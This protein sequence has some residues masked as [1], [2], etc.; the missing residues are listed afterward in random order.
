MFREN[1][2]RKER[3]ST[4]WLLVFYDCLIFLIAAF[5]VFIY[6]HGSNHHQAYGGLPLCA[7]ALVLLLAFRFLFHVYRQVWRSNAIGAYARLLIADILAGVSFVLIV[8]YTRFPFFSMSNPLM[9]SLTFVMLNLVLS[10]WARF[11]YYYLFRYATGHKKYSD[12]LRK[13]L[14]PITL[15]DFDTE[16]G[17][18]GYTLTPKRPAAQPINEIMHVIAQFAIRGKVTNIKPLNKGYINRSF[19]VETVSESGTTHRYTLQRI[20]TN[21]FRD[22]E[23]LMKNFETV[24]K[25]LSGRLSLPGCAASQSATLELRSTKDGRSYF[26]DDSGSWRMLRYVNDVHSMDKAESQESFYYAGQAFARFLLAVSDLSEE[27]IK[28]VIPDFHNTYRYYLE[29]EKVISE[30]PVGR[31][32]DCTEEITYIREHAENLRMISDALEAGRIPRRIAHNDTNLNNIL[33][34]DDS[35]LPAAIIDLD[36][37]MPTTP[38]YD[39]G[40][41]IRIG[42]NTAVDDEKDLSKVSCNMELYEAYARGYLETCGH[43]LT[44]EELDLLPYAALI[45]ASEDSIRFLMDHISGDTYY[46]IFYVGQNLDRSRTQLA[47]VKD[48][49]RKLPQME[50]T[51]RTIRSELG[52]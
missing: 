16:E 36:T 30:D 17:V 35:N 19:L 21:V 5:T 10:I 12:K 6:P 52:I 14:E 48:M 24:T 28:P 44:K 31:A 37:V 3:N 8:L 50:T 42:A 23:T 2:V 26:H 33:F 40:D 15:V 34:R 47:L 9:R 20:N 7:L 41:S 1:T 49:E 27:D 11:I 22:V 46:N 39:F 45:I 13:I 18:M 29:L 4:R 43:I 38:L 51:L 25:H 32:K